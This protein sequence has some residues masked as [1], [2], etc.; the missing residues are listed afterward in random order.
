MVCVGGELCD[1]EADADAERRHEGEGQGVHQEEGQR[2]PN[3]GTN[4][5]I[6]IGEG[7]LSMLVGQCSVAFS[8]PRSLKRACL[9][10]QGFLHDTHS[11]TETSSTPMQNEMTYLCVATAANSVHTSSTCSSRP[12]ARPC[13]GL[14]G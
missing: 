14:S 2:S 11:L 6:R 5:T 1:G 3:L 7:F 4:M 9:R 13:R 10:Q 12:T 8:S